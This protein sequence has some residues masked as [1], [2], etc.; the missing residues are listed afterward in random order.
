MDT[1]GLL[2]PP[3]ICSVCQTPLIVQHFV[4]DCPQFTVKRVKYFTV[5][6][7]KDLFYHVTAHVIVDFIK[8]IGI[9]IICDF[10]HPIFN[11]IIS[12]VYIIVAKMIVA[13]H[14]YLS[15][16][17]F[18]YHYFLFYSLLYLL[19]VIVTTCHS[20]LY[21]KFRIQFPYRIFVLYLLL[22]FFSELR[23]ANSETVATPFYSC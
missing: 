12:N 23:K 5:S 20:C 4:L 21:P 18:Y 11:I 3:P 22:Q 10:I 13:S 17:C 14:F 16:S 15:F 6:S 7:L 19:F 8:D 2:I 1:P 9:K